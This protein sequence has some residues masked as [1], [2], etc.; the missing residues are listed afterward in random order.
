M[1]IIGDLARCVGAGNCVL[2]APRIF[3]QDAKT[4]L[5]LVLNEHPD[6]SQ[7]AAAEAAE[8]A[9]PSRAV[10]ITE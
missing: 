7:R 3:T 5:V 9:C 4:G 8:A 2:A 1:K 10:I 6:E